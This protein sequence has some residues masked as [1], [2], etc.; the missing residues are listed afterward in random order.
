MR[1]ASAVILL[2]AVPCLLYAAQPQFWKLE[3][4]RDFLEGDTEG[5]SVDSEGRVSLAPR[6]T[7]VHD[8]QV[9]HVWSLVRDRAG[10]VYSGTGNEGRVYRASPGGESK[11][12]FD[13]AELE[14]HALALDDS[15]R[16]YAGTSPEGKV[17]RIAPDGSSTVV[18]DP[19]DRYIWALDFD[20]DGRLLVATGGEGHLWRVE[21]DGKATALLTTP[22][23]HVTALAVGGQGEVYAGSAP[24]GI[25]YRVGRDGKVFVVHDSSYREVKAL[26]TDG[27]H[28]YAAVIEGS[29]PARSPSGVTGVPTVSASGQVS[30]VEEITVIGTPTGTVTATPSPAPTPRPAESGRVTATKGAVLRVGAGGDVD[31]VWTSNEESPF[32]LFAAAGTVLVGTGDKGK[33]YR[34][35]DDRNW[36][37]LATTPTEQVTAIVADGED[38]LVATANPGKVYRLGR[39]AGTRGVFT[40]KPKDAETVAGWGRVRWE[41]DLPEGTRIEIATRTGNT[42]VP[43]STWSDWSAPYTAAAGSTVTSE[44]A[45]FMQVRATLTGPGGRTPVLGALTTSYLQRNLRPQVTGITVHPPGE[46]FQ[47]PLSITGEVE[48]MGFEGQ[49]GESRVSTPA[50][51]PTQATLPAATTYARKMYQKGM[52]TFSWKAEDPNDDTL[53]Y[54][55]F[56]R[57]VGEDRVRPLRR[58]L[59]EAVLAWDTTTV[60][61][62]RYVIRVAAADTPSNPAD[63]RLEGDKESVSFEIDNT[64]PRVTADLAGGGRVRVRVEDDSSIVRR[65]EYSVDGGRWQ[66][67]HPRD[68]ISDARD[69]AFEFEPELTEAGAPHLVVVR[70]FDLLNN[71][72]TARVELP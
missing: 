52:Q 32:S 3:G 26:A 9:P 24:G 15:G 59:H 2:S 16:L 8:P 34:V 41:A 57:R 58:G 45:R 65:A 70:A 51:P 22:E 5:V 28:L 44:R 49:A 12:L 1:R 64:P 43:D 21:K 55:V 42:S 20:A 38:Y 47:K 63:L 10:V 36:T 33:V 39:A 27:G 25:L 17:Y 7:D 53:V 40:S 69:E 50:R 4:A 23:T 46:V 29:D 18:Y 48:L 37:M 6:L 54:D 30:V 56:Y 19:P 61:N 60:P 62:G 67:I 14:V 13:A 71:V 66:E 35:R 31:T 68:G 72:A 11:L